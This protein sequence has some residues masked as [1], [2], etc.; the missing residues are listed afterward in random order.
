MKTSVKYSRQIPALCALQ[1]EMTHGQSYF[2]LVSRERKLEKAPK[3][4]KQAIEEEAPKHENCAA[5]NK[6]DLKKKAV[7]AAAIKKWP[8][9]N[10]PIFRKNKQET[11][12]LDALVDELDDCIFETVGF[13]KAAI[14][15]HIIDIMN[16]RRRSVRNG[17]DYTSV[18]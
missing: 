8:G 3:G 16:E 9:N 2:D 11:E 12:Q 18:R 4:P 6:E 5:R 7:K 15:Q 17:Y 14:R 13:D 1:I 10:I